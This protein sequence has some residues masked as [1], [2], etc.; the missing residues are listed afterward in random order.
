MAKSKIEWTESTWN[1]VTGCTKISEGC[2]NCYA[3]RMAKRLK[4]MGN[5]KYR[6]GFE[7]TLHPQSLNEP[8]EWK[9]PRRIFV[10]SM[11]D[12]FHEQVPFDF[13]DQVFAVMAL[14]PQH[15]FIVL[16][17]RAERMVEYFVEAEDRVDCIL[18]DGG[19]SKDF[20]WPLP[21]VIGMVTVENQKWADVRTPLLL[22]CPFKY[23]GVSIEPMLGPVE[24]TKYE[25][26]EWKCDNCG[27]WY[28]HHQD[29]TCT[30]CGCIDRH[31]ESRMQLNW[32]ICGGE[33][34]PGA[35][36]IDIEHARNLKDQCVAAGVPFFFKQW[37]IDGKLV[38]MPTLDGRVWDQYPDTGQKGK[39]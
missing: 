20:Q 4:G 10:C 12:L 24:F 23:R 33:S 38:K 31:L 2:V 8:L 5:R 30:H 37:N 17:K 11:S 29:M 22:Q 18:M 36:T 25:E 3:E 21:N 15:T 28:L 19:Y 7:L 34:G 16:T 39:E 13:I 1:S 35:R 32:V 26:D 27:W 14:A 9:K 6:N